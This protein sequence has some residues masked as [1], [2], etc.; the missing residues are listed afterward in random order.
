VQEKGYWVEFSSLRSDQLIRKPEGN[1]LAP[2][3]LK[4]SEYLVDRD[5]GK[6]EHLLDIVGS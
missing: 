1:G 2:V 3:F 6:K 5:C 4:D